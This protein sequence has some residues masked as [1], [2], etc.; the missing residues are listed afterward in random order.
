MTSKISL[1][2]SEYEAKVTV[3]PDA[4]EVS[5]PSLLVKVKPGIH[6]MAE[7]KSFALSVIDLTLGGTKIN[8]SCFILRSLKTTEAQIK[9]RTLGRAAKKLMPNVYRSWD[10]LIVVNFESS[11]KTVSGEKQQ[12]NL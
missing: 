3:I 4:M 12:M 2:E 7:G 9:A 10:D 11:D 1:V 8:L 6:V 5:T